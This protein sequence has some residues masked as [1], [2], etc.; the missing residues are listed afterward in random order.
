MILGAT[1]S[2]KSTL[3]NAMANYILGVQWDNEFRFE[4]ITDEASL[5]TQKLTAYTI[6]KMDSSSIP[7]AL[8]VID[9]PGF[10]DTRGLERDKEIISQIK[11]FLS[12]WGIDHLDGIGI[13]TQAS[14]A[15]MTP[16]Q[17]YIFDAILSMF[18]K[19]LASNIFMMITFADGNKP[20]VMAAIT[21]AEIPFAKYFKFNNSALFVS[22]SD[23]DSEDG[24]DELF[25]KMGTKSFRTMFFQLARAERKSLMLT[26]EVLEERQK[27]EVHL[28]KSHRIDLGYIRRI[29]N[30]LDEIALKADPLTEVHFVELLIESEKQEVRAGYQQRIKSLDQT[31]QQAL[32][33]RE[34]QISQPWMQR[35]HYW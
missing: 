4:L 20:P 34:A 13:V 29:L 8:T 15:R 1:G 26:K 21:A 32:L 23:T 17:R 7:Y 9:T 28:Q 14:F 5:S 10:G 24:F 35:S 3:I 27:L 18:G 6:H 16:T 19:N 12:N 11:E 25:W 22:S 33:L 2:G 31:K 30:R